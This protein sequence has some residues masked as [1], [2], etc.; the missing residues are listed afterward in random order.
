MAAQGSS[1]VAFQSGHPGGR[2]EDHAE[3][4]AACSGKS[5]EALSRIVAI[6]N[7]DDERLALDACKFIVEH[8]YGKAPSAVSGENGEGP[9]LISAV[10][11]TLD[12]CLAKHGAG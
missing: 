12:E 7:G 8:A 3:F 11:M 5:P 6:A 2:P 10:P 9:V 1:V 4:R